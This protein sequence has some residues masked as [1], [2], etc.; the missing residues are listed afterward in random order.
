MSFPFGRDPD[1][2]L[3]ARETRVAAAGVAIASAAVSLRAQSPASA[4]EQ[5]PCAPGRP[6]GPEGPEQVQRDGKFLPLTPDL[7]RQDIET[8]GV[9]PYAASGGWRGVDS[10]PV[11]RRLSAMSTVVLGSLILIIALGLGVSGCKSLRS[12]YKSAPYQ[13]ARS[14]GRFELRDYPSLTVVETPMVRAGA[15]GSFS[16]LFRFITGNNDGSRKIS[17]TTPVFMSDAGQERTMAFVMPAGM[18]PGEVPR[19]VDGA[20]AVRELPAGRFAVLRFSGAR[21]AANEDGALREL[22]SWM[23]ARGLEP[24]SGPVYAYFDPPWIP[25]FLRRNEVM[26]RTT[27][28]P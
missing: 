13:V 2:S 1:H 23:V 17:M 4:Q 3:L 14:D 5:A 24:V 7:A 8:I 15:D 10:S 22:R 6:H 26:Q 16:R 12:G 19:P 25:G 27:G 11:L 9:A 18:K 20:V 28:A 21:S